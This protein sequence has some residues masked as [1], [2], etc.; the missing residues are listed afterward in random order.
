[1]YISG[2]NRG[3]R[4]HAA[5]LVGDG[6]RDGAGARLAEHSRTYQQQ[7]K[8][9]ERKSHRLLPFQQSFEDIP[10]RNLPGK[11]LCG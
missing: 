5:C 6:A 8:S 7:T 9:N 3:A 10:E 2:F 4:N 1:L 11:C